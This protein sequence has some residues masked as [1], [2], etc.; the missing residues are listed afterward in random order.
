MHP[1]VVYHA[2]TPWGENPALIIR[3]VH[4]KCGGVERRDTL[5]I[6]FPLK[7]QP[8]L[9]IFFRRKLSPSR[10]MCSQQLYGCTY[11]AYC[12]SYL[13]TGR[14]T[15]YVDEM[16]FFC[17]I[18]DHSTHISVFVNLFLLVRVVTGLAFLQ[19]NVLGCFLVINDV[20]IQQHVIISIK[21][22]WQPLYVTNTSS[23]TCTCMYMYRYINCY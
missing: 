13:A 15:P 23:Y 22:T 9:V 12:T 21:N 2:T 14:G 1:G 20:H 16:V 19:L 10:L 3:T 5:Y 7:F 11:S 18:T 6:K 17:L 8:P 4:R